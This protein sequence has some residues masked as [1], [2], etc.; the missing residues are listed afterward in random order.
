MR[1]KSVFFLTAA[2]AVAGLTGLIAHQWTEARIE[3]AL[4][5]ATTP[6]QAATPPPPPPARVLVVRGDVAS[7]TAIALEDLH[8]VDWPRANLAEVYFE[9]GEA[10]VED[11]IGAVARRPIAA[12]Q[13]MIPS[14]VVRPGE[15]GYLAAILEPGMRAAAVPVDATSGIAGLVFPGDR[16]DLVLTHDLD[17]GSGK[18]Q[19]RRASETVLTA[20]RVLAL[21]QRIEQIE[22]QPVV[23]RTATLE[24][25]PKQVEMVATL[26]EI[27]RLSL[28]LRG[29]K[30]Q[31]GSADKAPAAPVL[32]R[33]FTL[34]TEVSRLIRRGPASKGRPTSAVKVVRAGDT[35]T[36][37]FAK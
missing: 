33:S 7:G 27:G 22:G 10:T 1:A 24:L 25:T 21:D 2:M 13:P 12:G 20:V 31:D 34:D 4:A 30:Q 16:V 5:Q 26:T 6:A 28:S 35:E 3:A 19:P 37:R 9:E 14:L 36:L 18:R 8:F 23:A 17:T 32:T 29:L 11:F 15:R